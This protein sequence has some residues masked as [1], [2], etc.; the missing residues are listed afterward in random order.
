[1]NINEK[2]LRVVGYLVMAGLFFI[3]FMLE[4]FF[5][6]KD[7]HIFLKTVTL[8]LLYTLAIWE[9]TR[10]VILLL[11]KKWQGMVYVRRRVAVAAA[12]LL[13]Y[14][15]LVGLARVFLEDYTNLWGIRIAHISVYSNII[16]ITILFIFLQV[17]IYESIYFFLEWDKSKTEA[18][19]LKRLN[20]QIQFDSLKVQIQPHFLFNSLNTLIGL[21]EID[22]GRARK[23][24]EEL[25]FMYRYFLQANEQ[26]LISLEE[27]LNFVKAYFFLLKTRYPEGLHLQVNEEAGADQSLVPPLSLQ[28]LLENAV[29]HNVITNARPLYI[30]ITLDGNRQEMTMTNNLQRKANAVRTG[31]G[32][33]HLKKKF[34]LLGFPDIVIHENAAHFT[35]SVPF[36]KSREYESVNH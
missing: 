7:E 5:W 25:A 17:A 22:T 24:T 35:V 31:K 19:E 12:I 28:L 32:L 18:E 3:F 26:E 11:R 10:M 33:S 21:M 6:W 1:V 36:I 34:H 9:P 30:Q 16:G 20:F 14:A 29:K 4:M 2:K 23:F 27:E 15:F 13:P 8:T